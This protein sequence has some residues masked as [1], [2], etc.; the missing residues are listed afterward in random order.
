MSQWRVGGDAGRWGEVGSLE[1]GR[2]QYFKVLE[3]REAMVNMRS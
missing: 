2:D 3:A 1:V